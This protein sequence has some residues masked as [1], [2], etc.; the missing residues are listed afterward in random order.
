MVFLFQKLTSVFIFQELVDVDGYDER[1]YWKKFMV[2][3]TNDKDQTPIIPMPKLFKPREIKNPL[4][5]K[6]NYPLVPP[7]REILKKVSIQEK[8]DFKKYFY[9]DKVSSI[10]LQW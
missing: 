4:P 10:L 5:A 7:N 2:V 3:V 6:R 8:E 1:D 9:I